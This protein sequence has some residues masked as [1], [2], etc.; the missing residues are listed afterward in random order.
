ML[1]FDIDMTEINQLSDKLVASKKD[2]AK[3]FSRALRRTATTL[4]KLSR[5]GLKNELQL[6]TISVIRKRLKTIKLKR[7]GLGIQL[8]YGLNDLPVSS[9][10]GTV[11]KTT[12][13]AM[14]R[15]TEFKGA[16]IAKNMQGKRTIFK[17]KTK[18][19][20]PISEQK[21][22]VKDQAEVYIEDE[23]FTQL[24][25]IFFK[26]FKADLKARTIYGV[27]KK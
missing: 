13:G 24:D 6:R 1:E 7:G 23:I 22:P 3:A 19:S 4:A 9:F 26:Y 25:D 16:F 21:L 5:S 14:F 11:K 15:N 27:G 10:K 12:S 2:V 18:Q 8:W 17:R 20:F